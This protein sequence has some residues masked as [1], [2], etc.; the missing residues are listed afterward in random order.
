MLKASEL[1]PLSASTRSKL[2]KLTLETKPAG[3]TH[4]RRSTLAKAA[5]ISESSVGRIW[6]GNRLKPHRIISFKL[7]N[8]KN[9]EEQLE[10]AIGLYLSP[11]EHAV[12]L[13]CDEKGQIQVL[14]RTQP[15]L[16]LKKGRCQTMTHDNKR[17]GTTSPFA[18]MDV[19]TGEIIG[20]CME[21]HRHDEWLPFPRLIDER[22]KS[23]KKTHIICDNYSTHKHAK[24]KRD[25][26]KLNKMQSA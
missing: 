10:N 25:R 19:A 18:A 4:W 26:Q 23:E 2:I 15:G 12:V 13:S 21:N 14:D 3:L 9:F 8:D 17:N 24:V 5:G 20:K 16:P 1:K 22:A 6:T 11:S 7:S